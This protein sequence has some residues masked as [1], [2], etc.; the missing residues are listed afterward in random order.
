MAVLLAQL[1]VLL[2]VVVAPWPFGSVSARMQGWLGLAVLAALGCFLASRLRRGAAALAVPAAVGPL[3]LGFVLGAVQLFPLDERTAELVSPAGTALRNELTS[4]ESDSDASL[5]SAFGSRSSGSQTISLY[6]A[7]TR[8]NLALF[9]VGA[10]A[11]FLGAALFGSGRAQ[12]VLCLVLAVNGAAVALFGIVQKLTWNGLLYWRVPLVEDSQPFGPLVNRNNA[13]GYLNL[14]LAAA[15]GVAIWLVRR[16]RRSAGFHDRLLQRATPLRRLGR[17][18]VAFF[19]RLD[20]GQIVAFS[21]AAAI[22]AGIVCSLSR[23]AWI[24]T[25]GAAVL[26]GL[27]VVATR[28]STAP[29]AVLGLVAAAGI[30]LA[31]WIGMSRSASFRLSRLL[32]VNYS[33][34]QHWEESVRA[35]PDFWRLGSGLG[36]YRYVYGLYQDKPRELFFYHAENQY[37]EALVEAGVFGLGLVLAMIALVAWG[38]WHV[39]R[40]DPDPRGATFGM[41]ALFA[42]S[43]QVLHALFDFGLSIPANMLSFALVCGAVAGRAAQLADRGPLPALV[44]FPRVGWAP[45]ALALLLVAA[46]TWG[47]RELSSLAVVED[48]L[49]DSRF[50]E[51]PSAASAED[52]Q[53]AIARLDAALQQRP[54]D[55][56]AHFRAAAVWMQLYRVRAFEQLRRGRLQALDEA[57]VRELSWKLASPVVLHRRLHEFA[58]FGPRQRLEKLR[59]EPLVAANLRPALDQLLQARRCC[60]LIP[61]VHLGLGE[62]QGLVADPAGDEVHLERARRLAPTDPRRLFE[63][64]LLSFQADRFE[65][66]YDNWKRCLTFSTAYPNAPYGNLALGSPFL[67]RIVELA[68]DHLADV[69]TV[70]KMLPDAPGLLVRLAAERFGAEPLQA[71]RRALG[72][73][74]LEVLDQIELPEDERQHLRALAFVV[75]DEYGAALESYERAVRLRPQSVAWRTEYAGL[76]ER[77][78]KLSEALDQLSFCTGIAPGDGKIRAWRR[79]LNQALVRNGTG[80]H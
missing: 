64:G 19:A 73:R 33:P 10:A 25:A 79:R 40:Y 53:Q 41:V 39:L 60:P 63:L 7:S 2:A 17:G 37:L 78:G 56:E 34:L 35:V 75:R 67:D 6:P 16:A 23:G 69:E 9:A 31:G 66:A 15:L 52:L 80:I 77:Q 43:S 51:T 24:A 1:I 68:G 59:R 28:R 12:G 27:V 74:A 26:A 46:C 57:T 8:A 72:R 55:A 11:F 3:I 48:A 65:A 58:R 5:A 21:L 36:T 38:V 70:R 22:V 71:V 76:L 45:S 61:E 29:L 42:L 30:G 18:A 49:A 32:D 50:A 14:C 47:F 4:L 20:A 54:D 44:R 62:L 13:A